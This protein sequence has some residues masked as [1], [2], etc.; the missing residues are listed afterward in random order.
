VYD[1]NA[2]S[3]KSWNGTLGS[4]TAGKIGAYNGFF[5]QTLGASAKLEI[6]D[7]AKTY[8]AEEFLG[9]QVIKANP[10]YFSL[11]VSSESGLA[12]KA[13]FQFSEGGEFGIDA[14]DAFELGSLS[15]KYVSLASVVSDSFKLDTN[16]LPL[17]EETYD[18]PLELITTEAG[19]HVFTLKDIS[20]PD[21]WMV[22]LVDNEAG[23]S[24]TFEEDF[25]FTVEAGKTKNKQTQGLTSPPSLTSIFSA[26]QIKAKETPNRFALRI[27]TS[28]SV[29]NEPLIDLPETVELQQNYPN[30]FN[31]STIIQFGV[32]N[33]SKVRLEVFDLLGR[34][35]ATLIN[36]ESRT[37]GRYNVQFDGSN[38]A[39]GLYI[40]RLQV[41]RNI[42][43]KKMTL[44]K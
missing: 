34:K 33:T 5:V 43:T 6:P 13:W 32:P 38:L 12:N 24:S 42:I 14:S 35:V 20:F 21:S 30:P 1:H 44:I 7:S 8:T 37:A 40:Y 31:P 3:W 19:T 39:S 41:G 2:A 9:K 36:N 15:S 11:E 18:I 27:T 16:N 25:I 22:E 29:S 26:S 10:H 23:T 28:T 4:L 17:T